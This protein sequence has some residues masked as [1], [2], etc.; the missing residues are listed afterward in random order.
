MTGDA[1][2]PSTEA[3]H[4]MSNH[5][6]DEGLSELARASAVLLRESEAEQQ[7]VEELNA[8]NEADIEQRATGPGSYFDASSVLLST[9]LRLA[10]ERAKA[11]G[12]AA[13]E[14]VCWWAD[15]AVTAWRSS[16]FGTPV[17]LTRMGAAAPHTLMDEEELA[18]L[19]RADEHARELVKLGARMGPPPPGWSSGSDENREDSWTVTVELAARSGLRI[20]QDATSGIHVEDGDEPEA[21]RRRMWGDSWTEHRVPTF[22]DPDELDRLCSAVPVGVAEGLRGAIGTVVQTVLAGERVC[23]LENNDAPWTAVEIAEYDRLSDQ[24]S[25]LTN[26]LADYAGAITDALPHLRAAAASRDETSIPG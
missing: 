16:V 5:E 23:E 12:D 3:R 14:F 6:I 9:R 24:M 18:T 25:R 17:L 11:A 8:L 13:H 7:H 22:P 4:G 2:P 20:R 19:P 15:A 26:H 21:R 1:E 10:V